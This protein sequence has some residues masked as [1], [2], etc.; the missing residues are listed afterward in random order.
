MMVNPAVRDVFR[1][2]AKVTSFIRRTLDGDDFL[3][4]GGDERVEGAI[5]RGGFEVD[6]GSAGRGLAGCTYVCG[7]EKEMR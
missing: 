3:E 6:C 1:M 2:R 5:F 7:H 4:V